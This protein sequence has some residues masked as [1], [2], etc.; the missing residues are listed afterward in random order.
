MGFSKAVRNDTEIHL[1]IEFLLLILNILT[2]PGYACHV[3]PGL[4]QNH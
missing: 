3:A 2:E 1:L 4:M